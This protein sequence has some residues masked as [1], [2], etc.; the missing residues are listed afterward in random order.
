MSFA[1]PLSVT[2]SGVTT[3]LPRVSVGDDTSEYQSAD[4]LIVVKASHDIGKRKRRMLRL[5]TSKL[6]PD[7]FKPSENVKKSMSLYIVFDLPDEGYTNAEGKAVYDGFKTLITANSDL[8][9]TK[10]LGGES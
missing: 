2:I 5:D 7:V 6:A 9:I 3:P 8:L 1:E 4:G 10:L